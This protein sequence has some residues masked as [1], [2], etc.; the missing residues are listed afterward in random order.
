M[1]IRD[2]FQRVEGVPF[3]DGL[4]H[5]VRMEGLELTI[6]IFTTEALE[7]LILGGTR[8]AKEGDVFLLTPAT[9]FPF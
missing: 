5:G 8:N 3:R 6:S 9:A 2:R 7:G 1:C 4:F